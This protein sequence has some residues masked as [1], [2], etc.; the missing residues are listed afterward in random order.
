MIAEPEYAYTVHHFKPGLLQIDDYF[1]LDEWLKE[2]EEDTETRLSSLYDSY[3][4]Y[5]YDEI[6]G[7]MGAGVE[8]RALT[9]IEMKQR[10]IKVR[11]KVEEKKL[12]LDRAM[13]SLGERVQLVLWTHY[14]TGKNITSFKDLHE[15][16][17]RLQERIAWE[18]YFEYV[19]SVDQKKEQNRLRVKEFYGR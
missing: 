3:T 14:L 1:K 9:A 17:K 5:T 6:E 18:L 13:G 8:W 11:E 4:A 19:E 15:C 7:T 12:L 16:K 2:Y 10:L